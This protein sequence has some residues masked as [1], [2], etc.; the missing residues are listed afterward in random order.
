MQAG[1]YSALGNGPMSNYTGVLSESTANPNTQNVIQN[2]HGKYPGVSRN[3]LDKGFVLRT[4]LSYNICRWVQVGVT[5]KWTDGKPFTAYRAYMRDGQVAIL[6]FSSR[7]TNPTD[8]NFGTRHGAVFHFDLH[9]QGSW[10]AAGHPMTLQ[11]NC[12]NVWDFCHDLAE[13]AF[14]QDIP[15][16][17]RSSIILTVPTGIV[18]TFR[19]GL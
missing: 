19:V 7:G 18:T 1:G 3:D 14:V 9:A 13:F 4:Y 2:P 8:G 6:P 15:Q 10:E 16:A 5:G 11:V 17:F 12:Y